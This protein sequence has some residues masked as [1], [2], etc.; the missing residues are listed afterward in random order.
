MSREFTCACCKETFPQEWTE[1][2]CLKE[3]QELFGD[4]PMNQMEK[5][6]DDCFYKIMKHNKHPGF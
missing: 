2:E 4:M 1:E 3:K 5:V 6:C